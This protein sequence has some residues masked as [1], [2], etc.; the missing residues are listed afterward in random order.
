[1]DHFQP[2]Y[3]AGFTLNKESIEGI[4]A[5]VSTGAGLAKKGIEAGAAKK[6]AKK[7]AA[8]RRKQKVSAAPPE[9]PAPAPAPAAEAP[10][11]A[12]GAVPTWAIAAG[13]GAAGVIGFLVWKSSQKSSTAQVAA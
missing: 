8:A 13:L 4:T 6:K 5:L 12:S 3:G 11:P 7:D 9:A 10:A 1:M 2:A